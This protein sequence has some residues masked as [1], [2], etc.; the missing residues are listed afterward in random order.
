M[1]NFL[2]EG[3]FSHDLASNS[4]ENLTRFSSQD[5][6]DDV[7]WRSRS[8][9]TKRTLSEEFPNAFSSCDTI[10][11]NKSPDIEKTRKVH[12]SPSNTL[13]I[14][15]FNNSVNYDTITKIRQ[16]F[17]NFSGF[18]GIKSAIHHGKNICF[19]TFNSVGNATIALGAVRGFQNLGPFDKKFPKFYVT[20]A[21]SATRNL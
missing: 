1:K 15:V 18:I 14:E 17:S 2:I 3:L 12:E 9:N 8:K 21:K 19:V 13:F 16:I 7:M 20:Y 10:Y 5:N 11:S 6:G 4:F